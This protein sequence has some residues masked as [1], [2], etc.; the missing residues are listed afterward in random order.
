[1]QSRRA[2]VRRQGAPRLQCTSDGHMGDNLKASGSVLGLQYVLSL[3]DRASAPVATFRSCVTG[4]GASLQV[5]ELP[6]ARQD[7]QRAA[8]LLLCLL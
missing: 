6:R 8:S 5:T 3:R 1:M 2:Q 7:R 4:L